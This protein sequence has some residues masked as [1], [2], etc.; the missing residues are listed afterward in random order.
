M[1]TGW[2]CPEGLYQTYITEVPEGEIRIPQESSSSS[3]S[4]SSSSSSSSVQDAFWTICDFTMK[5]KK[6]QV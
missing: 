6:F 4:Y 3:S 1:G 2:D 5:I